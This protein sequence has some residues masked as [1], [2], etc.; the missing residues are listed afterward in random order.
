MA[1]TLKATRDFADEPT[2]QER[3]ELIGGVWHP[4]IGVEEQVDGD[5]GRHND[6]RKHPWGLD[7]SPEGGN[8]H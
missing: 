5:G 7:H 1:P 2:D 4:Q 8:K 3:R 6:N